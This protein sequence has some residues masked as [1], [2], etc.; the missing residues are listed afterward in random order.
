VSEL[1]QDEESVTVKISG[2]SETFSAVIGADGVASRVRKLAFDKAVNDNCYWQTDTYVAYFSMK[3]DTHVSNSRLQHANKG[4]VI[5][6]RPIDK[7]HA[8]CY[9]I[10]TSPGNRELQDAAVN[11][12]EDSQRALMAKLYQNVD[13]LREGAVRGMYESDDFYFTRVVQVRLDSWHKGRCALV[14]DAGYCP[15]P[16]TGQGTTIA[17]LGG[18]I[19]AGEL[20]KNPGDPAAAFSEYKRRFEGFVKEE[21]AIPL[22]GQAPKVFVPQSDLGVWTLRSIFAFVARPTVQRIL[23]SLP[24]LPSFGQQ[25]GKIQLPQYVFEKTE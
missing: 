2:R 11:G 15:S 21:G 7:T 6:M 22:G 24:S 12:T 10:V 5:W 19:L 8:S 9:L 25:Q 3:T 20:A 1:V 14:G 17:L 13:G 16:L 23:S 18:Y 4:R